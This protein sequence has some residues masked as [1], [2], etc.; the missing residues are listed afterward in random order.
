MAIPDTGKGP[1]TSSWMCSALIQPWSTLIHQFGAGR[2]AYGHWSAIYGLFRSLWGPIA[3]PYGRSG[4]GKRSST[5]P[6]MCQTWSNHDSRCSIY[7]ELPGLL[8]ATKL[9]FMAILSQFGA[10]WRPSAAI[11]DTGK[12]PNPSLRMC[13]NLSQPWSTLIH[14]F[15]AARPDYGHM[16]IFVQY[17]MSYMISTSVGCLEG[18]WQC[19]HCVW[20]TSANILDVQM[21]Y[22]FIKHQ[23]VS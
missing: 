14:Q 19:L 9:P 7:L 20:D 1:N 13:H 3:P 6:W 23:L 4:P 8:M 17:L 21:S 15:G 22:L 16:G 11:L 18:V 12:G 5:S 2:P 10:L